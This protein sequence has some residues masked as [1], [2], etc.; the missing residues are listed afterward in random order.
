MTGVDFKFPF[1]TTRTLPLLRSV[2]KIRPSGAKSIAH[3]VSKLLATT[4]GVYG[5][6]EAG[7]VLTDNAWLASDIFPA[8]SLA[9]TVKLYVVFAVSPVTLKDVADVLPT[10]E[11]FL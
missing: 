5:S 6:E 9:L 4:S 8:K 3:G 11:P 2:K 1:S 7:F 10:N